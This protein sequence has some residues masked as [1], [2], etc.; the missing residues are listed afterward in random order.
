MRW[1]ILSLALLVIFS[2]IIG[3]ILWDQNMTLKEVTEKKITNRLLDCGQHE[4][5]EIRYHGNINEHRE[6]VDV[7]LSKNDETWMIVAPLKTY[8]DQDVVRQLLATICQYRYE[9]PL[10]HIPQQ[11]HEYGLDKPQ[12]SIAINWDGGGEELLLGSKAPVGYSI[13][14]TNK[15]HATVYLGSQFIFMAAAKRLYD[16]RQKDIFNVDT[17]SL[18]SLLVSGSGRHDLLFQKK[19]DH[20]NSGAQQDGKVDDSRINLLVDDLKRVKALD[21]VNVTDQHLQAALNGKHAGLVKVGWSQND[22]M[23]RSVVFYPSGTKAY[24]HLLPDNL[25]FVVDFPSIQ[26]KMKRFMER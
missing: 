6:T 15:K 16:F 8:A 11:D 12:V 10:A 14:A 18:T 26:E 4:I 7:L 1:G 24:A 3:V 13:Y 25:F 19:N 22:G 21:F 17:K 9:R 2:A 20:W 5:K 23:K